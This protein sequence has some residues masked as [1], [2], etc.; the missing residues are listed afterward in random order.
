MT[1]NQP[2]LHIQ[3][4]TMTD[5]QVIDWT[6]ER[7]EQ[8]DWTGDLSGLNE[9]EQDFSRAVR[10]FLMFGNG[11]FQYFFECDQYG[12]STVSSLRNLGLIQIADFLEQA[13]ISYP[14]PPGGN[15]TIDLDQILETEDPHFFSLDEQAWL[16]FDQI[17]P[18]IAAFVRNNSNQFAHLVGRAPYNPLHPNG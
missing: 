1:H 6:I 7:I 2:N 12:I 18:A 11:G 8:A 14:P 9:Y 3:L 15:Y 16:L 5:D 17:G 4:Q 13:F 10:F